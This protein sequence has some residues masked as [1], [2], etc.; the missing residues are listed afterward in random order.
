[1]WVVRWVLAIVLGVASFVV[2]QDALA[3]EEEPSDPDAVAADVLP[4]WSG[5]RLPVSFAAAAS[6]SGATEVAENTLSDIPS[7]CLVIAERGQMLGDSGGSSSYTPASTMKL[8]TAAAALGVL[9][10]DHRFETTI[11]AAGPRDAAG[12][13]DE[14]WIVGGGDPVLATADYAD[15]LSD[16]PTR[17]GRPRT[18]VETLVSALAASGVTAIDGAVHVDDSRQDSVRSVEGWGPNELGRSSGPLGALAINHGYADYE[19]NTPADDPA[20]HAGQVIAFLAASEGIAVPGSVDR[21]AP[22]ADPIV[23]ATVQSPPLSEIVAGMLRESDNTTAE[24]LLREVGLARAGVG[25]TA[26]G[27][28]AGLTTIRDL[29]VSTTGITWND[30]SGLDDGDAV[31]CRALVEVLQLSERPEFAAL[32]SGLPVAG[33]SGTLFDRFLELD[34]RLAA[35][36]GSLSQVTALAGFLTGGPGG[37]ELT[38]AFIGED[39][40]FGV[41]NPE[42]AD[43]ADSTIVAALDAYLAG[44]LDPAVLAP[45]GAPSQ[46][47]GTVEPEPLPTTTVPE[48]ST[49]LVDPTAT[50]L[51]DPLA[52]PIDGSTTT[53]PPPVD[54]Q[55][56][57][58][59]E[60]GG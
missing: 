45:G 24:I 23:L 40:R 4:V 47:L 29:G 52:E 41:G 18:P 26:A 46:P 54:P 31:T 21:A 16:N 42:A 19:N 32:R 33:E 9:G 55:T 43:L 51:I 22:P 60:T 49:T 38:F 34:G 2:G 6:S 14:V 10:P 25:S 7:H 39:V 50:T 36:T 30:G 56:G 12:H 20:V 15:Y 8:L 35:K 13:V 44:L 58:P 59:A 57:L 48:S 37:R 27:A 5:R 3:V 28:Q 1:M 17:V 11:L 53:E